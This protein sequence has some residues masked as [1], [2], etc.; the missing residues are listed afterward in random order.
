MNHA[1][2]RDVSITQPSPKHITSIEESDRRKMESSSAGVPPG[3]R[4]HPTDEEL[5]HYYLKKKVSFQKFDLE[6]I[7][8][9]DLNKLE[10]WDL[11]GK[12]MV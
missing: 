2:R 10:P 11:Q 12:G 6:V 1:P 9:V 3:F 8:E 7:R 5:L 4:F